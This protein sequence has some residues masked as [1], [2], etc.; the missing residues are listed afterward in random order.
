M[1]ELTSSSGPSAAA[2]QRE[3]ALIGEVA[4][5][6]AADRS[7]RETFAALCEIMT[8]LLDMNMCFVALRHGATLR[9][10]YLI[11]HGVMEAEPD[12]TMLRESRSWETLNSG[13]SQLFRTEA[14]W[15]QYPRFPLSKD[16]AKNDDAVSAIF[17]PLQAAGDR[18]GVLSVQS[19]NAHA[20][21]ETDV[22]L[23]EAI[24]RY[25]AIALRNQRLFARLQRVAEV[26]PLTGLANHSTVL[27]AIDERLASLHETLGIVLL[28][29]TNFGRLNDVYGTR[30]GDRVLDMLAER[31]ASLADERTLVGRFGGDDFV[32]VATREHRDGVARLVDEAMART[33]DLSFRGDD[34][35]IPVSVNIGWV[36]A[37]DEGATRA[38]LLALAD[39]RLRLSVEQGGAPVGEALAPLLRFGS[40]GAVEPLVECAL[41]RDPYTRMHLLHANHLAQRWAP[42]LALD[43][44][45]HETFIRAALLHDV[46]K[47]LVP[48]AIL[49]KPARLD[50]G[51]YATMQRHAEYG[52]AILS[53]Y[54][55][56]GEVAAIIGQHHERW[57][58]RG[59]PNRL[60]GADVHPLARAISVLDA[61]SAMTLDRPYHRAMGHADALAELQRCAGTQF[62]PAMVASFTAM[63]GEAR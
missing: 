3:R 48:D 46:G 15:L 6:L 58:G 41:V 54:E 25:L 5:L 52:R 42:S 2:D 31:L 35:V 22:A 29:I 20:Y 9:I 16:R 27:R 10:E 44:A 56:F 32:L 38:E 13:R 28:D 30:A 50:A 33:A 26:D 39:L 17:V 53:D 55:G 23:L 37:P 61:Y 59:Y 14:D 24:A 60:T 7:P 34:V 62:E 12:I 21:D 57:D 45:A 4:A 63:L 43:D 1:R 8:R 36:S 19:D 40:F 18:L 11:D 49:L 51:E 47:L